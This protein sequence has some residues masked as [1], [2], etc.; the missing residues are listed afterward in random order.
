M[1]ASDFDIESLAKYLHLNV[2]Q[3]TRMANR[4][5]L[6]GRRIGGE[7]RFAEAEIHHWLEERIGVSDDEELAQVEDVLDSRP[8]E[9]TSVAAMLPVTAVA[10]QMAA[11]TRSSVIDQ[12]CRLAEA[13]GYL[14][15]AA[16][17]T[18]A[19]RAREQLH[20]TALDN[21][22]ALLHPR[23]PL[24][25]VLSEPVLA[26]GCT[27]QGIPFGHSRGMMT[28]VFFLICSADD[29]GHLR[30]LARLSRIVGDRDL[31]TVLRNADSP[32]EMVDAVRRCE[33]ELFA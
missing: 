25:G 26:L 8:S 15:D 11:R 14:W 7:W 1:A 5:K 27:Q 31:L 10:A 29:A 23:R 18:E 6:P 33:E 22:V 21:G 32:A 3:V 2:S 4:G 20:P 12:M 19:V 9:F 13:S 24:S 17:M 16:K 30:T 28:D